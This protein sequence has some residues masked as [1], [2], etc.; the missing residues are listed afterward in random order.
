MFFS[1][2][3]FSAIAALA[4]AVSTPAF[5][6]TIKLAVTAGPHAEIAE[7]VKSVAATKGLDIT[8]VEFSEGTLI[9]SVTD[10]GEVDANSFQH[11][12]W[13]EQQNKDRGLH[14]VA[15]G[16][17]TV[18]LPMA[19]YSRKWKSLGDLP[20]GALVSLPG[21]PSNQARALNLLAANGVLTLRDGVGYDASEFDIV[22]NPKHLQFLPMENAQLPRSLDDVDLSI[23]ISSFAMRGGLEPGR[24]ALLIEGQGSTYFCLIGVAEKN[25]DAAWVATLVDAYKSPEVKDFIGKTYHGNIVTSW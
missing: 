9:N 22:D 21:D 15:V 4:L 17:P 2:T 11:T 12:P 14:V 20:D 16:G 1:K 8:V 25:K 18:L 3:L 7:V 19:G 24:D 23:I 13:L 6:Q 10:D 5:A